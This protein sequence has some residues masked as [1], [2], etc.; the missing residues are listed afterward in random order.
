MPPV[1]AIKKRGTLDAFEP[2]DR[3]KAT[4]EGPTMMVVSRVA[5]AREGYACVWS[6]GRRMAR[7]VFLAEE[8]KRIEPSPKS[9]AARRSSPGGAGSSI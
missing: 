7:A 3:V 6:I 2:G 9:A 4:P 8:L 1:A 5:G